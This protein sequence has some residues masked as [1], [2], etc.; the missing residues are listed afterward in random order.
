MVIE[1]FIVVEVICLGA[2]TATVPEQ[3]TGGSGSIA[4]IG[5]AWDSLVT[6]PHLPALQRE[7]DRKWAFPGQGQL[8]PGPLPRKSLWEGSNTWCPPQAEGDSS[9][10][11]LVRSWCGKA[12]GLCTK[13]WQSVR[14]QTY[15]GVH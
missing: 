10:C 12:Q 9:S 13:Y 11:T 4:L 7:A 5:L 8:G 1:H 3:V 2:G 14:S 6:K 15:H